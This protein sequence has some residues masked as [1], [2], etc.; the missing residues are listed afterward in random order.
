MPLQCILY[1]YGIVMQVSVSTNIHI[2]IG[3]N[4]EVEQSDLFFYVNL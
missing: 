2:F 4:D 1:T 3:V